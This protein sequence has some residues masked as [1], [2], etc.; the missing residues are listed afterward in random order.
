MNTQ[1]FDLEAIEEALRLSKQRGY[2][3]LIAPILVAVL[4][5]IRLLTEGEAGF[6]KTLSESPSHGLADI[7]MWTAH[8]MKSLTE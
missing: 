4:W 5:A 1:A 7:R 6:I 8:L 3:P 2:P